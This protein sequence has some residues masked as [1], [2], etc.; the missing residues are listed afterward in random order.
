MDWAILNKHLTIVESNFTR[1][2]RLF[3]FW[4]VF[5]L[6]LTGCGS[7]MNPFDMRIVEAMSTQLSDMFVT[8]EVIVYEKEEL[9]AL[10]SVDPIPLKWK[11]KVSENEIAS[12]YVVYENDAVYSADEAGKLTKYEATT[13]K[14]LW[15]VKTKHRFSAGVGVGEG[16]V[17]LGTFKGEVLAYNESGHM[18]WQASVTSEI[19]SPPQVQNNI[20]VVRTVDGRIFGLDAIDGKRKW[21]HQGATPPLTV[22]STAGITLSHGAVF[23]GFPGG[24]MVAMSLFNGNIGWE[25]AVSHPRGVTEL[26]RMTDITSVPV[27]SDRLVCAVAY[28]GRVA[29]FAINDGT[30]IWTRESSSSAGLVMDSDYVY[31]TEDKGIVSA[32]DLL[33]GAS[34]WKQSRLGSK[35][36]TKPVIKGQYIVVGDD[37]GNVNLLRNYDGV[38]IARSATDGSMIQNPASP[39]PDGFVVQTAKG[40]VYAYSTQF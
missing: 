17:L 25:V 8:D 23:A 18:L 28:Q 35:K 4:I 21:I 14:Q 38:L 34:V 16:L 39:L 12:F 40:G 15:Q 22:R 20:V 7:T 6:L 33:S 27:V 1:P 10:K 2:R 26:E 32:Y 5:F 13:G 36:L 9:D 37:Q 29:C 3:T 19:L 11:N 24:K 31:V 30:Q